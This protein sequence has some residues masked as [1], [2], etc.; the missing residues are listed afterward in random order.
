MVIDAGGGGAVVEVEVVE[1]VP[2]VDVV[3]WVVVLLCCVA[4]G[5]EA[6]AASAT[7][8]ETSR[9]RATPGFGRPREAGRWA[10]PRRYATAR[11]ERGNRRA[12][13]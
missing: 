2:A 6:H 7:P 1:V 11:R 10:M 4:L 12:T 5:C 3:V 9:A 8:P 13:S